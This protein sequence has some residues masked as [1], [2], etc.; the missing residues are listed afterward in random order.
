[1]Y[2]VDLSRNRIL[3]NKTVKLLNLFLIIYILSNHYDIVEGII[4]QYMSTAILVH[5]YVI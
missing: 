1:M 3:Q 2:K 5:F 4:F